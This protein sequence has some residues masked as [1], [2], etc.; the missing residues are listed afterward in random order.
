MKLCFLISADLNLKLKGLCTLFYIKA[1][2]TLFTKSIKMSVIENCLLS[3]W[4]HFFLEEFLKIFIIVCLLLLSVF[5]FSFMK[6][7]KKEFG[8]EKMCCQLNSYSFARF[9][10]HF[11][12]FRNFHGEQFFGFLL[13]FEARHLK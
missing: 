7:I 5:I 8:K 2:F 6:G 13:G 3:I 9:L 4:P 1:Y 12:Q 10:H 11:E